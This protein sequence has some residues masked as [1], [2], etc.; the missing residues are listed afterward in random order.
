MHMDTKTA[1]VM[2]ASSGVGL[3]LARAFLDY[4]RM[5]SMITGSWMTQVVRAAAAFA[6]AMSSAVEAPFA[7]VVGEV[8]EST[9]PDAMRRLPQ[10]CASLGLL[11]SED[12]IR[13]R[14]TT[15]LDTLRKNSPNSV[16]IWANQAALR[17]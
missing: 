17:S 16:M 9:D 11:T 7:T 1:I 8:A 6:L 5:L 14:G 13:Y 3:A 12:G 10:T 4:A 15:L 2:G